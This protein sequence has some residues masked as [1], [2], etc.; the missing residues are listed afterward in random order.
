[1]KGPLIKSGEIGQ[2]L[3]IPPDSFRLSSSPAGAQGRGQMQ[4]GKVASHPI[5]CPPL[6]AWRVALGWAQTHHGFLNGV[7]LSFPICTTKASALVVSDEVLFDSKV[8]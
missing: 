3:L 8:L 5:W 2:C 4:R 6:E 1:M 7:C